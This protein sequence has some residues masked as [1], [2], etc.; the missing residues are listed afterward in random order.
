MI[1]KEQLS[2]DKKKFLEFMKEKLVFKNDKGE[3][4]KRI[5]HTSMG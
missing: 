3:Y 2:N 1:S 4:N 5:T